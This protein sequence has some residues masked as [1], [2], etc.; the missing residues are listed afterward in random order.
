MAKEEIGEITHFFNK[1]GVAILKINSGE[2]KVGDKISIEGK[3]NF[4]Q[5]VD[6]MQIDH[7]PVESAK[8]G[9]DIGLK[10]KEAVHEGD[11][12]LKVTED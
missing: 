11:K 2:L 12:V 7:K 1:I 6:S 5:T 4:E 8:P 10:V 9:D 3:D